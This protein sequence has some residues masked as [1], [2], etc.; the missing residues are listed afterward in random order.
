MTV[1]P[2]G[3]QNMDIAAA[4]SSNVTKL[5]PQLLINALMQHMILKA[6]E[7]LLLERIGCDVNSTV[8][9]LLRV[10]A[11]STAGPMLRV[12]ASLDSL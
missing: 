10:P 6:L 11:A 8:Q 3:C 1:E 2:L 4:N 9:G 7:Q 5:P 12:Q